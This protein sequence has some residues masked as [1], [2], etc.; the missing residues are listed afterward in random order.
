[1]KVIATAV[2][3]LA[4]AWA[5]LLF[6]LGNIG[7]QRSV[8]IGAQVLVEDYLPITLA[9]S[10]TGQSSTSMRVTSSC[11]PNTLSRALA[12]QQCLREAQLA[13]LTGHPNVHD[14]YRTARLAAPIGADRPFPDDSVQHTDKIDTRRPHS[15]HFDPTVCDFWPMC[16]CGEHCPWISAACWVSPSGVSSP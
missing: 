7:L 3:A 14:M 4:A 5:V 9:A 8:S 6:G 11:R 2:G 10:A 13:R 16:P 12:C 1:M 15:A